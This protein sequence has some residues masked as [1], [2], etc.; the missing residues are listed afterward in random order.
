MSI[1]D[2]NTLNRLNVSKSITKYDGNVIDASGNSM[3]VIGKGQNKSAYPRNQK[4]NQ[5]RLLRSQN[6]NVYQHTLRTRFMAKFGTI[7][8]D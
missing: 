5:S 6:K 4:G 3:N 8:F 7:T 2:E 1:I